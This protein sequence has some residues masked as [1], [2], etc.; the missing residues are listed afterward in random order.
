MARSS[1]PRPSQPASSPRT[2]ERL[3][4]V[5]AAAGIDS[6]RQCETLIQEGRVEVDGRVITELGTRVDPQLQEI[7]VDGSAL[8][9]RKRVYYLVNKPKG[10]ISTHRDPSG[11]SRVIDLVP[12]KEHVFPVG[13]LDVQSE[14]LILVTNDGDLANR[15]THPRYSIEKTYLVQVAGT[16]STDSLAKLRRGM[17]L[18]EGRAQ[19]V[20]VKLKSHYKNSAVL[21][22]VLD[23]GRNREIRRLLARIGHKVMWLKRV[24]IGPLK[25]GKLGP[26]E[27]RPLTRA[28][29][30]LLHSVTRGETP[31]ASPRKKT[32]KPKPGRAARSGYPARGKD[33]KT[34]K[35]AKN[36]RKKTTR[37]TSAD[38]TVIGRGRPK[39][40]PAKKKPAGGKQRT[41]KR[42]G[43]R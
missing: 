23:E 28:E 3:Q 17:H 35:T 41:A 19:P 39:R 13:R 9:R 32:T 21:E 15:L 4:K 25:L 20:R 10:V 14:G 7:R 24:A 43:R 2:G 42:K 1:S 26:G 12:S 37:K 11:R 38:S 6:R 22:M 8:P 18:A 36:S 16:P 5:L 30:A 27:Y 33:S 34:K 31:P 40:G 29:I